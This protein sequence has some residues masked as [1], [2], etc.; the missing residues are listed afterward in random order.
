MRNKLTDLNRAIT[1]LSEVKRAA[2]LAL[3]H[4]WAPYCHRFDGLAS[5][6][7]R[8]KGCG[9]AMTRVSK[10]LYRCETCDITEQRTAQSEVPLTFPKLAYLVA[11]GNRAGKTQLGAQLAVAF[12]AGAGEWYVREWAK[13]NKLNTEFL[14]P[15]PSTVIV[16]GLSYNDS[17]EYIRPKISQYLPAG[18]N[19]RNWGGA[20]RG[21][22]TL[23]NGGRIVSMS[24]DS[25]RE[26][27]QGMG[28]RGLRAVSL[29]WLDEE[30]PEPIFDECLLRCADTPYG[31]KLLLTLTPLKGLTWVHDKF[32][33][34]SLEGFAVYGLS[35]LDNPYVS[36]VA[37]R[38][39]TRHLSK[40]SQA[41]RLYGKFT[42]QQGL[43]Y[44]EFSKSIHVIP[45]REIPADWPIFR[46][47]D[48][49]TRN[50]FCCLWAALDE[51]TDT[52]HIYREYFKTEKT[53]LENGQ[54]VY[55]F[56]K[57]DKGR[58]Q[59]TTCDPESKDGRLTLA[60]YC[61]IPNKPAPKHIGVTA[62]IEYV[63]RRLL[64]DVEGYPA[65]VIHESCT[66]LIREFRLYRWQPNQKTDTV[67]KKDD[68]GL[69]A[70]RYICITLQRAKATGAGND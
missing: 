43:V 36:S 4:L 37:L 41:S 20:G 15:E 50:P 44:P 45:D 51:S 42:S 30:H 35:G 57:H 29:A 21:V 10:G 55:T 70:L 24:A 67:I 56:S 38:R 53:T 46:G 26:K 58:V 60:R 23:P 14:P 16:S 47:I 27:Y 9:Q 18:C 28:G 61:N 13:L 40:E 62:G 32:I 3:S 52:L 69:D 6:S 8:P 66:K 33:E 39:A 49:G 64:T 17:V 5:E 19:F 34:K 68:H 7:E 65:L 22:V 31:G 12:A 48:F 1:A 25:G 11:G 2:P 54:A 59:W 63:K